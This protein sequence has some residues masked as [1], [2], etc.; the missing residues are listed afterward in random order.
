MKQENFQESSTL[1][2]TY[3][4][5][6]DF[7]MILPLLKER[8]KRA[9][10]FAIAKENTRALKKEKTKRRYLK[11]K[12]T[13]TTTTRQMFVA[14]PQ[15]SGAANSRVQKKQRAAN[16]V[17]FSDRQVELFAHLNRW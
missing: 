5:R 8:K 6:W 17:T 10:L 12:K 4:K 2:N 15:N 13:T 16:E 1:P 11:K 14:S 3:V 9:A 7:T